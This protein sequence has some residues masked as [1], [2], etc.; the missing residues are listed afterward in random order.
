MSSGEL[1]DT[2]PGGDFKLKPSEVSRNKSS[3]LQVP[4]NRGGSRASHRSKRGQNS[5]AQ[6]HRSLN[7]IINVQ[8][9]HSSDAD[10]GIP[11]VE[12]ELAALWDNQHLDLK[13][14]AQ[15][16]LDEDEKEFKLNGQQLQVIQGLVPYSMDTK[17][18][19][20]ESKGLFNSKIKEMFE[21]FNDLMSSKY[22]APKEDLPQETELLVEHDAKLPLDKPQ[23]EEE[24]PAESLVGLGDALKPVIDRSGE[25]KGLNVRTDMIHAMYF[26]HSKDP[27]ILH[28]LLKICIF[29][30]RM[31][32]DGHTKDFALK[33][34]IPNGKD[35]EEIGVQANKEDIKKCIAELS[36]EPPPL[37]QED[38]L[39]ET[40]KTHAI[41][42]MARND[43]SR[44]GYY[45][46]ILAECSMSSLMDE[47]ISEVY[48]TKQEIEK[49]GIY[50]GITVQDYLKQ[51][52]DTLS[53][54]IRSLKETDRSRLVL[55]RVFKDR[56]VKG[57]F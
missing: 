4:S 42:V 8:G 35:K 44:Q 45:K 47:K 7:A 21:S 46:M 55:D 17:L 56:G 31:L 28:R 26:N 37:D 57:R 25:F 5:A 43:L 50:Q 1:E 24:K 52:L 6:S 3:Q 48:S 18:K 16:E 27:T 23:E 39:F 54:K 49:E 20:D 11:R 51:V 2:V 34:I 41:Q 29:V 32:Q 22:H 36:D 33:E 40:L 9:S 12:T 14:Q 53:S 38:T 13:K 19:Y 30:N 15:A 10:T